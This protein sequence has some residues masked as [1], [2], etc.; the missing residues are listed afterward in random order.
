MSSMLLPMTTPCRKMNKKLTQKKMTLLLRQKNFL[1]PKLKTAVFSIIFDL[2]TWN[3]QQLTSYGYTF[4][5]KN[6]NN[7]LER[8]I[9]LDLPSMIMQWRRPPNTYR[10]DRVSC[11]FLPL[12]AGACLCFWR[13][14]NWRRTGIGDPARVV[15]VCLQGA[16][17]SRYRGQSP[18]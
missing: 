1:K 12:P 18:F 3:K 6:I 4:Q 14:L 10:S 7:F 13:P 8:K 11:R 2:D 9:Q 5:G 16:L 15:R 17:R